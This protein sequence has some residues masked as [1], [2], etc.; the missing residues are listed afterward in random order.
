MYSIT[1]RCYYVLEFCNKILYRNKR[2]NE[3][4]FARDQRTFRLI[5]SLKDTSRIFN[6]IS[7]R[8]KWLALIWLSSW[9]S[10][11]KRFHIMYELECLIVP[12]TDNMTCWPNTIRTVPCEEP[13]VIVLRVSYL[14]TR[15]SVFVLL[16]LNV[17]TS[18]QTWYLDSFQSTTVF[19]ITR[20]PVSST[21][22]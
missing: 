6:P 21:I 11:D 16:Q 4:A 10:N 17:N 13:F 7:Y 18:F 22:K 12:K 15:K 8:Q 20:S 9:S 3:V 19:E 1:F 2:E 5:W 14:R